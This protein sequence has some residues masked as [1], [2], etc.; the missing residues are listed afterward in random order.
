MGRWHRA[1][2]NRNLVTEKLRRSCCASSATAKCCRL[3][4]RSIRPW[5]ARHFRQRGGDLVGGGG[6]GRSQHLI[7]ENIFAFAAVGASASASR[8]RAAEEGDA[9][10][11]GF[12]GLRC[13]YRARGRTEAG[14]RSGEYRSRVRIGPD[15]ALASGFLVVWVRRMGLNPPNWT[16]RVKSSDRRLREGD[17]RCRGSNRRTDIGRRGRKNI[18]GE[19]ARARERRAQTGAH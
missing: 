5:V 13:R 1:E 15:A 6:Y 18:A 11:E 3:A 19:D 7:A 17:R 10:V 16:Q 2:I 4:T 14:R 8:S 12:S 9:G